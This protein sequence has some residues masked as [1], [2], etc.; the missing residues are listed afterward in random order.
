[1]KQLLIISFLVFVMAFSVLGKQPEGDQ[2]KIINSNKALDTDTYINANKLL[3]MTTNVGVFATDISS[4]FYKTDGLYYPYTNT[5]DIIY[6]LNNNSV[7]YAAGIWFGGVDNSTNDTLVTIAEYNEEYVPGPMAGGTFQPD[8]ASF[9]VYKLYADSMESNPNQDYLDWP[10]DQGAPVDELGRP[11]ITGDQMLWTVFN[12]AD[13]VAH[14]NNSGMTAPNGIEVQQRIWAVDQSG[15]IE[16][17]LNNKYDAQLIS[18]ST[19]GQV[20]ANVVNPAALTGHTYMVVFK[21]D[22]IN[23]T[24]WDLIDVTLGLTILPNQTNQSGDANYAIIDGLKVIVT[25][26]P[27]GVSGWSV[28]SGIRN[29]A[30]MNADGFEWEGFNGAIGWGGPGDTHGFG[31]Y[32]PVPLSSLSDVLLKFATTDLNGNFDPNDPNVSFGYRYLRNAMNSP[33]LPEFAPYIINHTSSYGFQIFEKNIPLSAWNVSV[34][35]PQRL[36]MGFLENNVVGGLV[37]GKYFPG[38][39]EFYDNTTSDGPR[40]WLWIYLDDYS[41]TPNPAYMINAI[42]EPMPIMYWNTSNRRNETFNTGDEFKIFGGLHVINLPTDTFVFTVPSYQSLST[43]PEGLSIYIEHKIFNK[44]GKNLNNC[45]ASFWCDPDIGDAIDD[46]VGCDTILGVGYSYNGDDNDADYG[47]K[48]PAVG[49]K[50]LES[51]IEFTGNDT[52]TATFWGM[53]FPGYRNL[54]MTSFAKYINGTDPQNKTE[55]YNYMQGLNPDGTSYID[56]LGNPNKFHKSGDPVLGVGDVDT[57]LADRRFMVTS[58]PFDFANGDSTVILVKLA[59]GQG[60]DRLASVSSLKEILQGEVDPGGCCIFRGDINHLGGD[61]PLDILD[62]TYLID[63]MFR[64]GEAPICLEEADLDGSGEI[65]ITDL[66]FI[67]DFMFRE[68]PAPAPCN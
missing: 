32:D 22:V 5:Y 1:M 56:N 30:S 62:L 43:G 34:D 33:A 8:Q 2:D 28:P 14:Q 44:G 9:R 29:F 41:E 49:V 18:G 10:V 42:D 11:E 50:V 65:D 7:V 55:A 35:P 61:I 51:P 46:L 3:M 23:G 39:Y 20:Y 16:I 63:Y 36:T 31:V 24:T 60:F 21:G 27:W 37:D 67:I 52:D 17:P 58:G 66:T 6:G 4:I 13:P 68:G 53:K 40:E 64:A 47:F 12:D 26:L 25:D 48:S 38:Y 54:G 15:S 45:Y 59:I 19:F 57:D